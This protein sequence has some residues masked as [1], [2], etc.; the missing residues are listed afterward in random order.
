MAGGSV[1][2]EE[3]REYLARLAEYEGETSRIAGL[4]RNKGEFDVWWQRIS[5]SEELCERWTRRI[6]LGDR[7]L[8]ELSAEIAAMKRAA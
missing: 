3:F 2:F 1:T 5:V 6:R 7:F 8:D 4:P